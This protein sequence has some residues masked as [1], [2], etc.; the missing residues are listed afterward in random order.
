MPLTPKCRQMGRPVGNRR[1]RR[2]V[3]ACLAGT[4]ILLA[5]C[6]NGLPVPET[7]SAVPAPCGVAGTA[8]AALPRVSDLM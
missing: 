7:L 1:R 5:A 8:Q 6:V 3:L 2:F 4:A